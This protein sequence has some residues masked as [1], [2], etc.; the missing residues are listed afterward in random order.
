M[1]KVREAPYHRMPDATKMSRLRASLTEQV[2]RVRQGAAVESN[3]LICVRH[4]VHPSAYHLAKQ[5]MLEAATAMN[6]A[7]D[8]AGVW[9]PCY[10]EVWL[11]EALATPQVEVA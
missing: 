8:A 1:K 3:V 11:R 5:M 2:E 7:V 9:S 6:A 10:G 4:Y